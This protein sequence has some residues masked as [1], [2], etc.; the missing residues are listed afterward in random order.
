M[1]IFHVFHYFFLL[2]GSLQNSNIFISCSFNLVGSWSVLG[3]FLGR[4][5]YLIFKSIMHKYCRNKIISCFI[6]FKLWLFLNHYSLMLFLFLEHLY[7]YLLLVLILFKILQFYDF[8]IFLLSY[9]YLQLIFRLLS[10]LVPG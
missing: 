7:F 9:F 5:F 8:Y 1:F 6:C 4:S 10:D 2:C 3:R